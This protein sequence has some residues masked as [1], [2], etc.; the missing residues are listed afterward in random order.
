MVKF[1]F[2]IPF[3]GF[4][5][6]VVRVLYFSHAGYKYGHVGITTPR[7]ADEVRDPLGWDAHKVHENDENLTLLDS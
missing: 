2:S 3:S 4:S 7:P 1:T 5:V 6:N